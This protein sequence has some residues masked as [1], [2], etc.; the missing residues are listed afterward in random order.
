MITT[1]MGTFFTVQ[2]VKYNRTSGCHFFQNFKTDMLYH[3]R[4]QRG[5]KVTVR[6]VQLSKLST[7]IKSAL[8]T[9]PLEN[10]FLLVKM[11][12]LRVMLSFGIV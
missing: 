3:I 1:C 5:Q 4:R 10:E 12:K 2:L 6:K 7:E 8:L 9:F 11:I